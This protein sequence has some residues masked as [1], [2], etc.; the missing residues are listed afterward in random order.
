MRKYFLFISTRHD[1]NIIGT[2]LLRVCMGVGY[3]AENSLAAS[4]LFFCTPL[5]MTLSSEQ[6][7]HEVVGMLRG[8][9]RVSDISRSLKIHL[10]TV[11]RIQNKL[12]GDGNTCKRSSRPKSVLTKKL[13]TGIKVRVKRNPERSIRELA[14][15]L[16]NSDGSVRSVL[17]TVK[18][19]NFA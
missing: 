5:S 15:E 18:S 13:K 9:S 12:T 14:S 1:I 7:R 17:H 6:L 16:K 8:S 2:S 10:W 4:H 3:N 11:Y 19:S